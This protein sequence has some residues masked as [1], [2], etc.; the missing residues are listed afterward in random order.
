[1]VIFNLSDCDFLLARYLENRDLYVGTY[2]PGREMK[3]F[4]WQF[5]DFQKKAAI[6]K[7]LS[8]CE[9]VISRTEIFRLNLSWFCD[10]ALYSWPRDENKSVVFQDF[11]MK[12]LVNAL[13]R[14]PLIPFES[15]V[16]LY[17]NILVSRM[18]GFGR[19]TAVKICPI[20]T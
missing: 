7:N 2:W 3:R 5:S 14:E 8:Y 13:F 10:Q 12:I 9:R 4:W 6:F 18:K 19:H 15:F 11:F 20:F 16:I 17:T 1:M